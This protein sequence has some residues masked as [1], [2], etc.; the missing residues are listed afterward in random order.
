MIADGWCIW[1]LDTAKLLKETSSKG[2]LFALYISLL[3]ASTWKKL[4]D[5]E[6]DIRQRKNQDP[7]LNYITYYMD[8][9]IY[10]DP[11]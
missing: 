6:L 10:Q 2:I 11:L 8:I 5:D 3:F 1:N 9:I 4:K 7:F